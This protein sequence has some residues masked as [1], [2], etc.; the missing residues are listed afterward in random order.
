M[1]EKTYRPEGNDIGKNGLPK[2]T[3]PISLRLCAD[4]RSYECIYVVPIEI[5]TEYVNFRQRFC[6]YEYKKK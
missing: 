3:V 1:S 4:S 5:N 6:G 2:N